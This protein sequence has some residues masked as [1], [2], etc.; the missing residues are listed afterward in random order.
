VARKEIGPQHEEPP[1]PSLLEKWA[2]FVKISHTVFALPFALSAT[3]LAARASHAAR[4]E[5]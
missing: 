3:V 4:I 5:N 2:D 1:E